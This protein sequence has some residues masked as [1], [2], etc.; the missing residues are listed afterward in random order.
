M[1]QVRGIHVGYAQLV[2][3]ENRERIRGEFLR[4]RLDRPRGATMGRQ[5]NRKTG[6][7]GIE[8]C[9]ETR[10]ALGGCVHE[11]RW[12]MPDGTGPMF[13]KDTGGTG[14]RK[15]CLPAAQCSFAQVEPRHE[16]RPVRRGGAAWST[17]QKAI[18]WMSFVQLWTSGLSRC[19]RSI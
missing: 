6:G 2:L 3:G 18:R 16:R 1:L 10:N 19:S 17:E 12:E 5:F 15:A 11:C 8:W 4:E 14:R 9:D 13:C 7:R